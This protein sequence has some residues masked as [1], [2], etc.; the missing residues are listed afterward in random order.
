M[1]H[2]MICP[3]CGH[4]FEDIKI[5]NSCPNCHYWCTI[6]TYQDG[7][8]TIEQERYESIFGNWYEGIYHTV[9]CKACGTQA[10]FLT[11]DLTGL[12]CSCGFLFGLLKVDKQKEDAGRI[13]REYRK[14]HRMTQ[15]Q[16]ADK[17]GVSESLVCQIEIKK[18]PPNEVVMRYISKKIY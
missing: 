2:K 8:E 18:R 7:K 1:I 6:A 4:R 17:I 12:T 5:I 16:L 15:K 14:L 11:D 9:T 3:I 10:R 13:L